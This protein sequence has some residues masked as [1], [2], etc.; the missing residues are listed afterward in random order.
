MDIDVRRVESVLAGTEELTGP[1]V[2]AC[3]ELMEMEYSEMHRDSD[4]QKYRSKLMPRVRGM[5]FLPSQVT[6][7]V[8]MLFKSCGEF[9]LCPQQ[10]VDPEI[11]KKLKAVYAKGEVLKVPGGFVADGAGMGK[12]ALTMA[13]IDWFSQ[14]VDHRD[15]A[16]NLDHRPT[17]IMCPAGIVLKQWAELISDCFPGI[18]LLIAKSGEQFTDR[19]TRANN[20]RYI[21]THD[22]DSLE[23]FPYK[24][25]LDKNNPEASQHAVLVSYT[26]MRE[27][28]ASKVRARDEDQKVHPPP[29]GVFL[30]K[31][32]TYRKQY[33]IKGWMRG[34]FKIAVYDEGHI[35]RNETSLVHW[36]ARNL[37]TDINW[38]VTATPLVNTHE[39]CSP[40]SCGYR[41][42]L[43][44]ACRMS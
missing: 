30:E 20:W 32:E 28:I 16:G 7:L 29:P 23:N 3:L 17:L 37:E 25:I 21:G 34:M 27:R 10:K 11:N 44:D 43:T 13:Y 14:F 4:I 6:G 2:D 40:V 33:I 12:T 42:M 22:F 15:A 5:S 24:D 36:T 18:K 9:P 41:L 35:L 1:G 31:G 39:V 8:Y 38:I 26:T 19:P